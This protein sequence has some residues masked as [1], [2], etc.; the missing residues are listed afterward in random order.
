MRDGA[1]LTFRMASADDRDQI[2][3]FNQRLAAQTEDRHLDE[4]T[5]RAGVAALLADPSKG[6]YVLAERDGEVVGQTMVT[7][8]WSDW[9]NAVVWWIQSVYVVATHRR[10]GVY[11]ALHREIF[12]RAR[13]AGACELR[14]YVERD[15]ARARATYE[16]LGMTHSHYDMY[17][18]PLQAKA[19][20]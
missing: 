2:A 11:S 20:R 9:R 19:K 16:H 10:T 1:P 12:R 4:A 5:L 6:F 13:E 18:Q 14:L 8:E 17:E 15:N 7:Y 3:S